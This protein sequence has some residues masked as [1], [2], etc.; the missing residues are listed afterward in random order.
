MFAAGARPGPTRKPHVAEAA[1][2]ELPGCLCLVATVASGGGPT[3]CPDP[4]RWAGT[5]QFGNGEV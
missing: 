5:F 4:V 1:C 2:C 3:H